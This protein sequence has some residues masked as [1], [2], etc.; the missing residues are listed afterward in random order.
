MYIYLYS[1]MN[2]ASKVYVLVCERERECLTETYLIC[3][4]HLNVILGHQGIQEEYIQ[5]QTS[6][7]CRIIPLNASLHKWI[8][9]L[10]VL[11]K[12]SGI[13]NLHSTFYRSTS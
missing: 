1:S 7:G 6:H 12:F 2:S 11:S 10:I 9:E 4:D 3:R 8:D 5:N 13:S